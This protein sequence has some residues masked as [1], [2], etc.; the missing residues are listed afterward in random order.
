[1]GDSYKKIKDITTKGIIIEIDGTPK[2]YKWEKNFND[3][4]KSEL[5]LWKSENGTWRSDKVRSFL[6]TNGNEQFDDTK[7]DQIKE[8]WNISKEDISPYYMTEVTS[9]GGRHRS[10]RKIVRKNSKRTKRNSRSKSRKSRS[11]K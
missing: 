7:K 5:D 1:M 8:F 9:S 4:I 2:T 11:R 6:N 10:S 3:V